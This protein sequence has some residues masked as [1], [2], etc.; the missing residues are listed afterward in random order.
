MSSEVAAGLLGAL[1]L[2]VL[3]GVLVYQFSATDRD[4]G[5]RLVLLV[6]G[7]LVAA[8]LFV[9]A[10]ALGI[11]GATSVSNAEDDWRRGYDEFVL[12]APVTA[13]RI[14]GDEGARWGRW[15]TLHRPSTGQEARRRLSLP[16][17]SGVRCVSKV[18]ISVG[19]TIRAGLAGTRNGHPGGW[20][21]I[22]IAGPYPLV[23]LARLGKVRFG[24]GE[25]VV[26]GRKPCAA[27]K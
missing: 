14:Y 6:G 8:A 17:A 19:V 13:F 4:A 2:L 10:L 12:D 23:R 1:S 25:P 11:H 20:T 26:A 22:E 21:Q 9:S 18:I 24:A 5:K 3:L 7:T 15:L 16:D 27:T